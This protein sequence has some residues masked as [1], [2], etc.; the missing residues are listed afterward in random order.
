MFLDEKNIMEKRRKMKIICKIFTENKGRAL[1]E[2]QTLRVKDT[3]QLSVMLSLSIQ[4][5]T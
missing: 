3:I 4:P 5:F 2:A 1:R